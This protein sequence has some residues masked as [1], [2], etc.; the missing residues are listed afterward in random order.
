MIKVMLVD[1]EEMT[2]DGLR[3][4]VAWQELGFS[5]VAEA[6]DGV[7]GL[8]KFREA[9]PDLVLCDVRMPR[10]DG[11]EMAEKIRLEDGD[12]KIVFLSG[13]SDTPYLKKA[14]QLHA[15]DYIEKP[16][17]IHELEELLGRLAAE[18]REAARQRTEVEA[19]Q[20]KLDSGRPELTGRLV[21]QL[22]RLTSPSDPDW[23]S[24]REEMRLFRPDF[25]LE[26]LYAACAFLAKDEAGWEQWREEAEQAAEAAELPL[27]AALLDGTGVAIVAVPSEHSLEGLALWL[28]KLTGKGR[29]DARPEVRLVAGVG[30]ISRHPA[31][32]HASYEQALKA[33]PFH[34]YRGWNTAIWYRELPPQEKTASLQLFDKQ[35]YIRYEEALRRKDIG[36]AIELLDQTVNELLLFP[37][38]NIDAV[39]KKLF[40]WYV[41]LTKLYPEAMWEF[42]KDE[43]WFSVFLT[44]ELYTIRSFLMR[45]LEIVRESAELGGQPTEKSVIREVIRYIQ[46]QYN[47]DVSIAAIAGHVYLTPTYLCLLFKKEKG[48][49]INDYITQFRIERAKMLLRDRSLKLYEIS[50][51]VGYQDANYFAK[52]FRKQTGMNPSEYRDTMEEGTG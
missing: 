35:G 17:Q 13:Y 3:E 40:R 14:I 36:A 30:E 47:N 6:A 34:F 33:L 19:M 51:F 22:L 20:R 8:E 43:L 16:V 38:R 32:V 21:K 4:F 39:R 28:N 49:S 23:P 24:V 44:G 42:E 26:G 31:A 5:V 11:L 18:F 41:A 10:M 45:R 37:E 48:I 27:L 29:G 15:V 2:R 25:P 1:D 9:G 50:R 12:C 46:E 52:V 7:Q